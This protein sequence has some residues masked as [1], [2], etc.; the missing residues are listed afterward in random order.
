[1][2]V[3]QDKCRDR[4]KGRDKGALLC[5]L[6]LYRRDSEQPSCYPICRAKCRIVAAH[7]ALGAAPVR[8][9]SLCVLTPA[10]SSVP[11]LTKAKHCNRLKYPYPHYLAGVLIHGP[12][13]C[14]KTSLAHW[15]A[16]EGSQTFKLL[17]VAC[18]DLVHKVILEKT[19]RQTDRQTDRH[20]N[21]EKTDR[22]TDRQT[23]N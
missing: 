4:D 7:T 6:R 23:K 14:G 22:Q 11:V 19:D 16:L 17:S 13:G 15:L 2:A 21:E 8:T 9:H 1:M 3:P 10:L 20:V 18:A 5:V 12:S